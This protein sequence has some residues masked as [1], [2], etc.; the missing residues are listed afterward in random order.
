MR[1]EE[2]LYIWILLA[3]I[4]PPEP[5]PV[6]QVGRAR[7]TLVQQIFKCEHSSPQLGLLAVKRMRTIELVEQIHSRVILKILPNS[8]EIEHRRNAETSKLI[9]RPNAR[10]HQ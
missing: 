8:R 1:Y 5:A 7:T 6:E 10:Q 2:E 9:G 4:S 3:A